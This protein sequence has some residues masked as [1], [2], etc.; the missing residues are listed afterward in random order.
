MH[1]RR[2]RETPRREPC[3]SRILSAVGKT[4]APIMLVYA[5]N[6][7]DTTAGKDVSAQLD[8]LHKSHVLKFILAYLRIEHREEGG[9]YYHDFGAQ[10][11][12][13]KSQNVGKN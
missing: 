11:A 8:R 4:A 10:R 1:R 13:V 5:A 7:F 3:C 6:D 2:R 9:K 12:D